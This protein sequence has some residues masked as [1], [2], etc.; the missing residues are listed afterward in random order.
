M[1]FSSPVAVLVL[2]MLMLAASP[3]SAPSRSG[4][5]SVVYLLDVTRPRQI[6]LVE[7]VAGA[8]DGILFYALIVQAQPTDEIFHLQETGDL[9]LESGSYAQRTIAEVGRALEPQT[10]VEDIPDFF[11]SVRSD[12]AHFEALAAGRAGVVVYGIVPGGT[13]KDGE[14]GSLT[15]R[16]GW[17]DEVE[18]F[19]FPFVV[20]VRS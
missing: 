15:L 9:A 17:G 5:L 8:L 6:T 18:S 16:Y 13:L 12:L 10:I 7:P 2:A 4:K 14:R 19:A 1:R 11:T 20:P 3:V